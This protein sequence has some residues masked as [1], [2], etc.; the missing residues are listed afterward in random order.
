[1]P[2]GERGTR[3]R[4]LTFAT[5]GFVLL[6]LG[7]A[8]SGTPP[9]KAAVKPVASH[10]S[11][12]LAPEAQTALVKQYCSTCHNDK[13]KAGGLSLTDFNAAEAAARGETSEKM[14]RKLRAGM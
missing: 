11:G 10:A 2:S 14:I 13:M 12:T 3:M 5:L 4:T 8:A 6:S 9:Q 1:M 7:L